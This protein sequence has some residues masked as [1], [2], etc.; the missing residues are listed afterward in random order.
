MKITYAITVCNEYEELKRVVDIIEKNIRD[1]D[2]ILILNDTNNNKGNMTWYLEKFES[3]KELAK[4]S[5]IVVRESMDNDF[6]KF[7][8]RIFDF[9][10][11][12]WIFQIDADE[13]PNEELLSA[14]PEILSGD[15]TPDVIVVPRINTVHNITKDHIN[16]WGW[17]VSVIQDEKVAASTLIELLSP[18]YVQLINTYGALISKSDTDV[19]YYKPIIN[20]PD[21]QWRLYRNKSE[22]RWVNKVHEKLS[23]HDSYGILPAEISWCLFH[24]KDIKRQEKQNSFY[25]T[26]MDGN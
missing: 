2:E 11:G 18:E 23:G 6:A 1:E 20:F 4:Y 12:D 17:R 24:E 13:Y 3:A 14:L 7:K 15:D 22:I 21:Y 16:E 10:T 5:R 9:A 25:N 19:Y 8:N 26:L